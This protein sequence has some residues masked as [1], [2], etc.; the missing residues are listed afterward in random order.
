MWPSSRTFSPFVALR[1]GEGEFKEKRTKKASFSS[2]MC[3]SPQI[4][5]SVGRI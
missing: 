3:V 2:V 1:V 5:D 4:N